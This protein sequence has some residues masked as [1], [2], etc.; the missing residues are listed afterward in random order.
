MFTHE[1]VSFRKRKGSQTAQSGFMRNR[2]VMVSPLPDHLWFTHDSTLFKKG[3]E[4]LDLTQILNYIFIFFLL[5]LLLAHHHDRASQFRDFWVRYT[6]NSP[7]SRV[8]SFQGKSLLWFLNEFLL[9]VQTEEEL[10][11]ASQF[12]GV[13]FV[14]GFKP[15]D[16]E[17]FSLSAYFLVEGRNYSH[18]EIHFGCPWSVT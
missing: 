2:C 16:C 11:L 1:C 12:E 6:R 13:I 9:K 4:R 8:F 14:C 17:V 7:H 5:L 15:P 3:S 10:N 18:S